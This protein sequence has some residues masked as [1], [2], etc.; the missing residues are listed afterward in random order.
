MPALHRALLATLLVG[1]TLL[2]AGV[3]PWTRLATAVIVVVLVVSTV[4]LLEGEYSHLGNSV[5]D[6]AFEV[7]SLVTSTGYAK[8]DFSNWPDF[9][10][11]LLIY[12]SFVGGCGGS[13]AGGMKVMRVTLL[14][15]QGMQQVRSLIHPHALIPVRMGKRTVEPR[16]IQGIWGFFGL[17]LA[18]F[19]LLNLLMIHAGLDARSA[20]AAVAT[21]M[22]NLG[23]GLGEV[24]YTFQSVSDMGKLL[25][26]FA[27]LLGR[28]EIFTL[29]VLL[30]PS[31]WLR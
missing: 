11:M 21:C 15:K 31:F 2:F 12:I 18:T 3:D 14:I 22:N 10:P 28:L 1:N 26:I 19:A 23:P 17:Y 5:Q 25:S 20:F 24:A 7:V 9:L 13:T 16:L 6:A 30:S 29:L 8:V 4:L 27:M